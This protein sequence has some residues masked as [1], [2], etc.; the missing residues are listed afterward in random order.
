MQAVRPLKLSWFTQ[1]I[2]WACFLGGAAASSCTNVTDNKMYECMPK[3][4]DEFDEWASKGKICSLHN[5]VA[6][7]GISEPCTGE[8]S[9]TTIGIVAAAALGFPP[10][11]DGKDTFAKDSCRSLTTS[12][13][14]CRRVGS[15]RTRHPRVSSYLRIRVQPVPGH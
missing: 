5:A 13:M 14:Q 15:S 8:Q 3:F 2:M 11:R 10:T 1:L 6:P 12:R 4:V 7:E 9:L